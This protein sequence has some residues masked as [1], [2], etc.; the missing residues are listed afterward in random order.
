MASVTNR[1]PRTLTFATADNVLELSIFLQYYAVLR[2]LNDTHLLKENRVVRLALNRLV[3][4]WQDADTRP[5]DHTCADALNIWVKKYIK[6]EGIL[7]I[8]P[9]FSKWRYKRKK[10]VR[11]I[12]VKLN[13]F[14]RLNALKAF[15]GLDSFNDVID[16]YV[17]DEQGITKMVNYTV[18]KGTGL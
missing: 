15:H 11:N 14:D 13:V 10:K 17:P 1:K 8:N 9:A 6:R 5:D 12:D 18:P 7:V 2:Q 4:R 3:K 16:H